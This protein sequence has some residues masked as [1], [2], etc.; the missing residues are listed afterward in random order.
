MQPTAD[1]FDNADLDE[2]EALCRRAASY[3]PADQILQHRA[4]VQGL[5]RAIVLAREARRQRDLEGK[6]HT[7]ALQLLR[8][9]IRQLPTNPHPGERRMWSI[10][11][12]FGFDDAVARLREWLDGL[13]P[14][15]PTDL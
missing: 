12:R 11:N 6:Q 10:G 2:L 9:S 13:G 5:R 8:D 3:E 14:R 1:D 7:D 4:V 15:N